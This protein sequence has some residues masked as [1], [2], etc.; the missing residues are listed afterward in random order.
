[1]A[2]SG[3]GISVN[4][5]YGGFQCIDESDFKKDDMKINYYAIRI[6]VTKMKFTDLQE[7]YKI[8]FTNRN[9]QNTIWL[10]IDFQLICFVHFLFWSTYDC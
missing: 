3:N 7:I 1:M 2:I 6:G 9:I 4:Y 5:E 10:I 8:L